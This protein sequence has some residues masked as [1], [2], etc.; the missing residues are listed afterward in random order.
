MCLSLS[1]RDTEDLLRD[2]DLGSFLIRLSDKTIGFILSYKYAIVHSAH[3]WTFFA[4][5]KLYLLIG[6]HSLYASPP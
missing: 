4:S 3:C 1:T 5:S 2:K 6:L